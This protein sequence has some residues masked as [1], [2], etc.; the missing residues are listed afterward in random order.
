MIITPVSF[1]GTSL[2]STD[3]TTSYPVSNAPL[4]PTVNPQYVKRAGTFPVMSGSDFNSVTLG[5]E[6][7][8]ADP[9]MS[10]FEKLVQLFNVEDETP[11]PFIIAD[12]S[13]TD[14]KQYLV[15][16]VPRSIVGGNDGNMARVSLS[17]DDPIWKS[18]TETAI[19][20][21]TTSATDSTSFSVGGNTSAYPRFEITALSQP[22]SDYLYNAFLQ[23]L[24]TSRLPWNNRFLDV[25]GTSDGTGL[26]TAALIAGGKMQA[27]GND[28]RLF[29]DGV[30]VDR[31]LSGVDTTDTHIITVC[32]MPASRVGRL[33]VAIT[34]STSPPAEVSLTITSANKT[35]ISN[36]PNAGRLIIDTGLGTTDTEEF[37]YTGKTITATKYAFTGITRAARGTVE[38]AH[39]VNSFVRWLPYDFNILYGNPGTD[40]P[41]IDEE[42]KPIQALTSRN[43]LLIYDNFY[44]EAGLRSGIWTPIPSKVSDVNLSNSGVFTSTDD[45]GDTDPSTA[46]GMSAKT[47]FKLGVVKADAVVLG[48]SNYFPD[49]ITTVSA[50]GQKSQSGAR[51]LPVALQS[52]ATTTFANLWTIPTGASI[53]YG[54]WTD[55]V[56]PSTDA[57]VGANKKALRWLQNGTITGTID[58][59]AKVAIDHIEIGLLNIPSCIIRTENNNYQLNCVLT[60]ETTGDALRINFPMQLGETVYIDTN[61]N[62]PNMK[63]RGQIVNGAVGLNSIRSEWLRL[64]PGT[65]EIAY[66]S[67]PSD[68]FDITLVI[69]YNDRMRFI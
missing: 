40:A 17:L 23:V 27:S 34:D 31:Q 22:S 9:F 42:R 19:N 13:T 7:I 36:M 37:T 14:N 57:V 56:K 51:W 26:D 64:V 4:S 65:N 46:I 25:V 28:L 49:V 58:S 33:R 60:N 5:L 67:F 21:A 43:N 38:V 39:A 48:W 44:D 16:A 32:D 6:I 10:T 50:T 2:Q 61:P 53:D 12:A 62:F 8:C 24:P 3:Y 15:Y 18:V 47:Y 11:R 63:Y 45:A 69:K 52:A 68:A 35:V 30:E 55:F 59:Y 29:R 66:E 54:T 1:N 41:I 20:F